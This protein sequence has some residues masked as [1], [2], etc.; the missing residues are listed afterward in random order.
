V[1]QL[2]ACLVSGLALA[3]CGEGERASDKAYSATGAVVAM[4]G[5]DGGPANACFS[6]HG[7]DG[8]GDGQAAPRLAGLSAG[9]LHKQLEDYAA[10]LRTDQ[11]MASIAGRLSPRARLAV[12]G[13]Y[14]ALPPPSGPASATATP[15][16]YADCVACHG[17]AGQGAGDAGPAI[18]GQPAAYIADQLDRWRTGERRNDPR[19]VMRVAALR[20]ST[21][22]TV[23]IAAWLAGQPAV[24]PPG[25]VGAIG[26]VS[27]TAW[28][29]P[30]ASRAS[31]R[32]DRRTGASAPRRRGSGSAAAG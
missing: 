25:S 28:E 12:A 9:Y 19:G 30:A 13:H 7:L 20:L 17:T 8:G 21:R 26:S 27:D 2:I 4:S 1:R 31:H 22:E 32:P 24:R 10:G 16:A 14:G 5:G 23:A 11:P 18:A 15:A 6:C 3:G 29:A